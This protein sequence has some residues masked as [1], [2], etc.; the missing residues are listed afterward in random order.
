MFNIDEFMQKYCKPEITQDYLD[1]AYG[2]NRTLNG[3]SWGGLDYLGRRTGFDAPMTEYLNLLPTEEREKRERLGD[4]VQLAGAG[5]SLSPLYKGIDFSLSAYLNYL[6]N[7]KLLEQLNRGIDFENI[8][9]GRLNPNSLKQINELR[10]GLNQTK[11]NRNLQI[12]ANVVKKFHDK[13][14]KEKYSPEKLTDM[15]D[16]LFHKDGNFISES[17]HPHIQE[18]SRPKTR[19][20]DV[21]YISQNPSNGQTV[22]KSIY[23]KPIKE[24]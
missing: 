13:R 7:K 17:N 23:R 24:H 18:I 2:A 16:T 22:V 3:L 1:L 8:S 11:L 9:F 19:I 10:K 21:G 20:K 5:L 15:A 14:L 6:G 4:M 12:P